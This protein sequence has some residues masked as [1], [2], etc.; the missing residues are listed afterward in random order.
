VALGSIHSFGHFA[1]PGFPGQRE[2]RVYVPAAAGK[3]ERCPVIYLFDGQNVFGDEGSFVGGWRAHLAMD[4]RQRNGRRT[5]FIVGIAHGHEHRIGELSPFDS[6]RFGPGRADATLDWLIGSL[7][8][9]IDR[10]LPTLADRTETTIGGSSM[11]GLAALYAL[12]RNPEVFGRALVMSPSLWFGGGAIFGFVRTHPFWQ[13]ARLYLDSGEREGRQAE[14]AE[15][16][17]NHLRSRGLEDKRHLYWRRDRRGG[18]NEVSWRR[19]LPA[20][21]QFVLGAKRAR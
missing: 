13:S 15:R 7:K 18:H 8:P 12:F 6:P 14:Q 4:R 1:I 11:G 5:A 16:L 9:E 10:R 17:A 3:G 2:V 21:L 19:R 20:A